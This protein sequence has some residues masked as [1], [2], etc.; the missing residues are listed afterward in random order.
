MRFDRRHVKPGMIARSTKGENLGKVIRTGDGSFVV[1]KGTFF[2]KDYELYYEYVTDARGNELFYALEDART[3]GRGAEYETRAP[4]VEPLRATGREPTGTAER[5]GFAGMAA[6]VAGAVGAK[7]S[8][9]KEKIAERFHPEEPGHARTEER[10][11]ERY[12]TEARATERAAATVRTPER[13]MEQE[14]EMRIP[15]VDEELAVEKVAKEMGHVRI[16]KEVRLEEKHVTVP[17][18]REEVVIEHLP[19]R[20][21]TRA[22][23]AADAFTEQTVD[24]P[25]NEEEVRVTKRPVVREEVRVRRVSH[26]E[27]RDVSAT[28]RHEELDIEDTT[29]AGTRLARES[30]EGL[31]AAGRDSDSFKKG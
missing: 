3:A 29:P 18:R 23:L 16:H 13:L 26:E 14:G 24:L 10:I 31:R 5:K 2:H 28:C 25:V 9:A 15:L 22:T 6:G 11:T 8:E 12:P 27:Q 17:V 4:N 21:E 30:T 19:A 1:E 7:A 20:E